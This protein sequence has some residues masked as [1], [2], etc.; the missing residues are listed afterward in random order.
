MTGGL[1]RG[2]GFATDAGNI[3]VDPCVDSTCT[4]LPFSPLAG[5]RPIPVKESLPDLKYQ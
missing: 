1:A 4:H 3:K 2:E 5:H